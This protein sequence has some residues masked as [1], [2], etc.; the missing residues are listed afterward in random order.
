[1]AVRGDPTRRTVLRTGLGAGLAAPLALGGPARLLAAN[2]GGF[3]HAFSP[4]GAVKYPP[5]FGAFDYVNTD[6]P[7]GGVMRFARMGA[8]DTANTLTYPGRPPSD[9]RLIYDR[10]IVA[11][12]DE[13]AS[14]YGLLAE[15][16]QVA[17]DFTRITFRLHPEARWHDGQPVLA[18]DVAFT[19]QTLKEAGAPFYRQAFRPLE[20]VA[21]GDRTVVFENSRVGDRD[22][23]RR[24]ATIPIHPAHVWQGEP[25]LNDPA[26]LVGSGPYR[27]TDLDAPRRLALERVADYWGLDLPVNQGRWN[28][29]TLVFSYFRDAGVALEAFRADDY[30]VRFEDSPTRWQS[31]YDGAS[32]TNGDIQRKVGKDRGAGEAHGIVFN[33]RRPV[34]A[35]RRVRLAMALA[36]DFEALNQTLFDGA[37]R[38]LTSVFGETDLAA[39]GPASEGERTILSA[40]AGVLPEGVFDTP[41]PMEGLPVAGSREAYLTASALLQEAG[42]TLANGRLIDPAT[43]QPISFKIVSPNPLYERPLGFIQQA[44][45]RLGLALERVQADRA[46][47]SRQMLDRD[48]DLATLSWTPAMLPGT[49]ERLLWHSDLAEQDGSYAL[50][51]LQNAGLDGAIEALERARTEAD[52][53]AAGR[54][55][56]RSFRQL[57]PMVP[58]WSSNDIRLA[59]WDRFG[60]PSAEE[61]GFPPSPMDRWWVV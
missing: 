10:L 51:G 8:F 27:V 33:L 36:V 35:D 49:A 20:V 23:V 46:T 15:S 59:W 57:I 32:L 30:D 24:I 39:A 4:L 42:L 3:V 1:M 13:R 29:E 28:V 47:A 61:T 16:F 26:A 44:W 48:F 34:L 55:F 56:D 40:S 31:G 37:Y 6:A 60:M 5:E 54:A 18:E 2:E 53:T 25:D 14:Y 7:K 38:A 50:S 45:D 19:F 17:E 22:V 52:L 9:I 43:D 11:S 41:N 21:D 58:L 12:D